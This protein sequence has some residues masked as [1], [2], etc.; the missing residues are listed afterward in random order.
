MTFHEALV[1]AAGQAITRRQ[2]LVRLGAAVLGLVSHWMA[3]VPTVYADTKCCGLCK[4]PSSPC[5][6]PHCNPDNIRTQPTQ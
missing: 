4:P 1:E 6:Y 5:A 2:F 3:L